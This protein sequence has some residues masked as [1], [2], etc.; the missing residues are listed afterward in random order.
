MN[1]DG[2]GQVRLL[3]VQVKVDAD[4]DVPILQ[5]R[6]V[7]DAFQWCGVVCDDVYTI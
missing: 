2:P 4:G 3:D 5:T 7:K 1:R 6:C